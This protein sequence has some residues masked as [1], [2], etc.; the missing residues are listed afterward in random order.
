M[1]VLMSGFSST[2]HQFFLFSW[3]KLL[4]SSSQNSIISSLV[5][6][7]LIVSLL[8]PPLPA[9]SA[10]EAPRSYLL[11]DLPLRSDYNILYSFPGKYHWRNPR[12]LTGISDLPRSICLLVRWP[13]DDEEYSL[14][15]E[16]L[17]EPKGCLDL[18]LG[19]LFVSD[20]IR[21]MRNPPRA[22][23]V[24]RGQV[25]DFNFLFQFSL[26]SPWLDRFTILSSLTCPL[27]KCGNRLLFTDV[28]SFVL[29][30]VCFS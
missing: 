19:L 21:S 13:G 3:H 1:R 28:Y 23:F 7:C 12:L 24:H 26:I 22:G 2:S 6:H 27:I 29:S 11:S 14:A 20:E 4:Y 10:A 8:P 9:S 5:S 25:C 15:E 16:Y 17:S 30:R 18:D